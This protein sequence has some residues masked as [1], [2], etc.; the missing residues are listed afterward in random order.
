MRSPQSLARN[1][2]LFLL[3]GGWQAWKGD[4]LG[5]VSFDGVSDDDARAELPRQEAI[6]AFF[7]G[8]RV[9]LGNAVVPPV[10]PNKRE[11]SG[12]ARGVLM[13]GR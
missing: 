7:A 10:A 3:K 13:L 2:N 11:N 5:K 12:S 1:P 9:G 6:R 8:E 4:I